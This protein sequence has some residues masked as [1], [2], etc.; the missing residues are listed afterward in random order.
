MRHLV[1]NIDERDF[2][3]I[4]S[5]LNKNYGLNFGKEKKEVICHK[6]TRLMAKQNFDNIKEYIENIINCR[7]KK[8]FNEF[9]NEITTHTTNFFR[10]ENHFKFINA[11]KDFILKNIPRI[12][13]NR[14]IRIWSAGCSSGEEAYSIAIIINEIFGNMYKIK[15]LATDLSEKILI[16]ARNGLY[17]KNIENQ[18]DHLRLKRYFQLTKLGYSVSENIKEM[19]TFRQFNLLAEF[20]FKNCFDMIFC[21]NVIIYFDEKSRKNLI[22]KLYNV[23][24]KKGILFLGHSESLNSYQIGFKYLDPTVYQKS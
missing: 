15:I 21:R 9:I 4:S 10:E 1:F 5:F 17:S 20:P 8:I 7:D 18:I 23:I 12:K 6:I 19:V 2:D 14:E 16:I 11:Q 24:I 13:T 22:K 3:K